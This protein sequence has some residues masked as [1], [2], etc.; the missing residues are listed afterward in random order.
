[1]VAAA[2]DAID[3]PG[4]TRITP[5]TDVVLCRIATLPTAVQSD[6]GRQAYADID[7]RLANPREKFGLM[8]KASRNDKTASS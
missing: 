5:E 3:L 8:R 4:G 7:P 6:Q 2:G 1:M